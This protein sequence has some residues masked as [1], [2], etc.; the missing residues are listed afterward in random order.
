[1]K[2]ILL[3]SF[4]VLLPYLFRE[5]ANALTPYSQQTWKVSAPST[6][7]INS[8][9]TVTAERWQAGNFNI[10]ISTF[11]TSIILFATGTVKA[12]K[13]EGDGSS[14]TDTG[15]PDIVFTYLGDIFDST[16]TYINGLSNTIIKQTISVSTYDVY[17]GSATTDSFGIEIATRPLSI[18]DWAVV[19][20]PIIP[21]SVSTHTATSTGFTLSEGDMIKFGFTSTDSSDPAGDITI[22]VND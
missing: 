16:T 14:L 15:S 20:T 9:T 12:V 17:I 13:F 7:T 3:I 11:N 1:M 10:G 18:T 6:S 8:T 4:I 2:K 21:A 5:D 19:E 22:K